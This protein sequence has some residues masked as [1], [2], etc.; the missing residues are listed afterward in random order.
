MRPP[1]GWQ[2][3]QPAAYTMK[4]AWTMVPFRQAFMFFF[5]VEPFSGRGAVE[6]APLVR[7]LSPPSPQSTLR[8]VPIIIIIANRIFEVFSFFDKQSSFKRN[9]NQ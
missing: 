4:T 3:C 9:E 6:G 2:E 1:V 5:V 7:S 8:I